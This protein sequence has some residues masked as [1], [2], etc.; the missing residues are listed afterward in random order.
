[1][2]GKYS[3]VGR[4]LLSGS[5]LQVCNLIAAAVASFFL[6]PFIV[7]HLGDRIY[8]FWTLAGAF[9]GYYS[10][11]DFGLSSAVSQ[12]ISQAIGRK[13]HLECLT[14]FNTALRINS[15]LGGI[16]LVLTAAFVMAAPWFCHNPADAHL[17]RRVLAVLGISAALG[18]PVRVYGGVLFTEFLFDIQAWLSFLGLALRTG[19]VVWA[20]LAGGGLLAL[21][22]VTL[23]ATLPVSGLQV[24]FARRKAS[25]AR[26]KTGSVGLK[27]AKSLSSYSAYTFMTS[28]ADIV[29]FQIDPLVISGLIGLA[30]VTHYRVAGLFAQYYLQILILSVGMLQPVMSRLYGSGDQ[31]GLEKVFFFGTK[32]SLCISVFI[33]LALFAWGR[34]LI[35]RWMGP[36]YEDAYWPLVTLSLSALLD[37]SQRTSID[38]LFATFNHRLYTYLNWA[39]GILNLVFSLALARPLGI[40]GVALGTLI[41]AVVVRIVVQPWWVCKVS[42]LHYG[43]YMRFLGRNVAY[44]VCLMGAATAIVAWGLRPSYPFLVASAICATAIYAIGSWMLVLDPREREHFRIALRRNYDQKHTESETVGVA[45]S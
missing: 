42:S 14:I 16:A 26:I 27:T 28:L 22:W 15:L 36:T 13:N 45:A 21:A 32:L 43:S 33:C 6:M 20:I 10:L 30:E 34:P 37:V 25:W 2:V 1:M 38:L 19:L 23:F 44:C 3:F 35:A 29:R 7:H 40:L 4:K 31:V 8:G 11:L 24:W 39:E 41:G 17:F 5:V 12:Y 9:I 18:F